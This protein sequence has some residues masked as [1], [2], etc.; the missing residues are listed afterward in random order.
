MSMS[1]PPLGDSD[2]SL[3]QIAKN[4][5]DLLSWMKILVVAIVILIL[6]NLA[7]FV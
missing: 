7:F 5:A 3:Q 4:T 6:I 1:S 2:A